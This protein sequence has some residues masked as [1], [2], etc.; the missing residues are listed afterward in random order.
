MVGR[1]LDHYIGAIAKPSRQKASSPYSN[2]NSKRSTYSPIFF[3]LFFRRYWTK[4]T[5]QVPKATGPWDRLQHKKKV[6]PSC[7]SNSRQ[8]PE[9]KIGVVVGRSNATLPL[10]CFI[11]PSPW[12]AY[13]PLRT[14][15]WISFCLSCVRTFRKKMP[16]PTHPGGESKD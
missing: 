16:I 2:S 13:F 7:F 14:S 6:K 5:T 1:L 4:L 10:L 8:G 3:L 11:R 12:C 9:R 15:S